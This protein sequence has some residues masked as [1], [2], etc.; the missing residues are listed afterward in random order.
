MLY[1]TLNTNFSE[2]RRVPAWCDRILYHQTNKNVHI[3]QLSYNSSGSVLF[4]DHKPV[5]SV[6][7]LTIKQVW[8]FIK[9]KHIFVIIYR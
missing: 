4:S 3:E 6:F 8:V 7:R 9:L 5:H 1:A 2:K